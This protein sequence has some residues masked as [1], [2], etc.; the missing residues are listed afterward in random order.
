MRLHS[1]S[2]ATIVTEADT[3]IIEAELGKIYVVPLYDWLW[4]SV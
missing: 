4:D 2:D 3:E 1:I